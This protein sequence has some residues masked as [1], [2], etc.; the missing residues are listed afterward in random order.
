M[1]EQD[2]CGRKGRVGNLLF[3]PSRGSIRASSTAYMTL[4]T[5]R[6]DLIWKAQGHRKQQSEG[7]EASIE[8]CRKAP[9]ARSSRPG[10]P[11][12]HPR[13]PTGMHPVTEDVYHSRRHLPSHYSGTLNTTPTG[14]VPLRSRGVTVLTNGVE[15][16]DRRT[17]DVRVRTNTCF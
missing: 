10:L 3:L 8:S 5:Y 4:T 16:N 7:R 6:F 13:V 2:A 17:L 9:G 11:H 12:R 14:R 1:E 15:K